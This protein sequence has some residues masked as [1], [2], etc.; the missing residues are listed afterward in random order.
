[1]KRVVAF[2]TETSL[3]RPGRPA[4]PISCLSYQIENDGEML[5]EPVLVHWTEALSPL[6]SWLEDEE[7]SF[8][9]QNVAYDMG[10][11]CAEWPELVPM[12]FKAYD[13]NRVTD[14]MLRQKLL[15]I[16]RGCYRG[17]YDVENQQFVK[18]NYSLLDLAKRLC[19]IPI[20]KEGFRL[21]Y[22]PL[23]DVS[24]DRWVDAAYELQGRGQAWLEGRPD[25][26]FDAL[27]ASYGDVEEFRGGKGIA[28]MVSADPREV[29]TYPLDDATST[30]AVYRAQECGVVDGR[31]DDG[32]DLLDDQYRQA[33][34]AWWL[35]LTAAWGL[36]TNLKSVAAL[37]M[38][39]QRSCEEIEARLI[40]A[41][42]VRKDGSRDTKKAMQR[43]LDVCGWSWDAGQGKY[44]EIEERRLAGTVLPLRTTKG[45]E[46]KGPQPQL[47]NDA[48]EATEDDLLVSYAELTSLKTVLNKD[49]PALARGAIYPVHTHFDVAATG[50]VTSAGP[51]VQNWRRL[52]GIRECFVPRPGRVF[53]QADY[54]GLELAT[55]AQVMINIF[56]RSTLADALNAGLDAHSAVA[57]EILGWEYDRTFKAYKDKS[58][59]EHKEADEARGAGKV[60]N[61][62]FPGG[63]GPK[64]FVTF[65]K[66]N[67][68]VTLSD[69]EEEAIEKARKLKKSW[70]AA[71]PDMQD[72]FAYI[73]GLPTDEI[74]YVLMQHGSNRRRGGAAYT[75]ACN[76]FFQGLGAD[77]TG[78]AGWLISKACYV[79]RNSPLFG[80]RIVNYIHDE[81]IVEVEAERAHEAAEELSR[82]MVLGASAWIPDVKLQAEPCLMTVWS[83]DAKTIRDAAGRLQ[84]W[85]PEELKQA[86]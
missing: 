51:N 80:A 67:Y 5:S 76:S 74:G 75:E 64:T 25:P 31:Y 6:R 85:S 82:L 71:W 47:D 57:A 72:Y 44:I 18:Y 14:T 68:G 11:V 41:G 43:M 4:P 42:L 69:D 60:A 45:G 8:V 3:I 36:R 52:P 28:G 35:H 30:M 40:E 22:G 20:K 2:D 13:E 21:F 12:V 49:V 39:T 63:L 56:G 33:R 37:Q 9:G 73:N 58:H 17:F 65:A 24:L 53:A 78:H 62:G 48:C 81:F 59:A 83:K 38:Q 61:F 86:A 23:R 7:T 79:D 77:A 26:V 15:D 1:M 27:A 34:K 55:L 32:T 46:K 66:K 10:V 54:S 29:I 70:Q 19:G 50:R 16:A 84:P